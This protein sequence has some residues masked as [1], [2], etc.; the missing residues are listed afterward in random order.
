[1]SIFQAA[2]CSIR[3]LDTC[4]CLTSHTSHVCD[5]IMSSKESSSCHRAIEARCCVQE[6]MDKWT[7]YT[8]L[9]SDKVTW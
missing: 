5:R 3:V 1:M 2:A 6:M 8:T 9:I 4:V 7:A